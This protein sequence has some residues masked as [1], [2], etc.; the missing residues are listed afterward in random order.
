MRNLLPLCCALLVSTAAVA[1]D[2]G[3][4]GAH[5][6]YCSWWASAPGPA[7]R[8]FVCIKSSGYILQKMP[9]GDLPPD[10]Q[11][12]ADKGDARAMLLLGNAALYNGDLSGLDWIRKSAAAKEPDAVAELAWMA[13]DGSL[14]DKDPAQ[15]LT[16]DQ[17]A[18]ALGSA[19]AMMAM[20]TRYATG[21]GVAQ[22]DSAANEWFH[23]AAAAGDLGAMVTLGT[24]YE[25]GLGTAKDYPQA[26]HWL[27][28]AIDAGLTGQAAG[29]LGK[30]YDL[31]EGVPAD[32]VQAFHWYE[33]AAKAGDP[34]AMAQI[35]A[36][37]HF[38][39][40]VAQDDTQAQFWHDKSQQQQ[41]H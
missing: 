7:K 17:Q 8:L 22:D 2:S 6:D 36:M 34:R 35:A 25:A 27:H 21:N 12:R 37:Y 33:L 23:K 30:M 32:P 3:P 4:P 28:A 26:M 14:I 29:L 24:R 9:D 15:A 13:S 11:A 10:A 5:A 20:G 40:G 38:G 16:L 31:G 39:R 18:A 19:P 41:Q 1:A